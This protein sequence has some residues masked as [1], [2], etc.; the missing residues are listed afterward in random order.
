MQS[1]ALM[2]PACVSL[3]TRICTR[4][5]LGG[6]VRDKRATVTTSMTAVS[7]AAF[8]HLEICPS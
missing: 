1:A 6:R 7:V 2:A 4:V 5:W 3:F 8:S